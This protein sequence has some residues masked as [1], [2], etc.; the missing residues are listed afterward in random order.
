MRAMGADSG[1][2]LRR[3]LART[4]IERACTSGMG[5]HE[6]LTHVADRVGEIVP[7]AHGAWLLTDPA[8]MLFTDVV[9]NNLAGPLALR[10]FENELF[11]RD[12]AKFTDLV[13]QRAPVA[14]LSAVTDGHPERSA[15]HRA[16]H[17]PNGLAGELRAVFTTGGSCWGVACLAR[18]A[19]GPDFTPEEAAFV[20]SLCEYIA[21]GLRTALLHEE[22]EDAS[23]QDAPGMVVLGSDNSVESMTGAAEHWL[24]ELPHERF[25]GGRLDLPS[26]LYGIA[27]RAR[28]VGTAADTGIPRA[29]LRTPS[30]RWLVLHASCLR[31]RVGGG[32]RVA[33][34]LEPARRAEL[35]SIVVELYELTEREQ[36]VTQLLVRG[37]AI[38]EIA[39]TLWISRHTVR[40]HVKSIFIKL[41]VSSRP[42][43]TAKLFAEQFLP[44]LEAG[45]AH[46]PD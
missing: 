2:G 32:E 20:A 23:V 44:S 35:A 14:I 41:D 8:T 25:D 27:V 18:S 37:L 9:A 6:L 33:V 3:E 34:V 17:R 39:Q 30:G 16:L 46:S 42:E 5:P 22:V 26:A 15:R 36:Q 12:Y 19:E 28:A 7:H 4:A 13:R 45:A 40:D 31:D 29:R 24:S 38:D 10:F 11:D 21:H 1:F 43:L